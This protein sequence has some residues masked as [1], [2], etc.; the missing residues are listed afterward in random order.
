M[1]LWKLIL[2]EPIIFWSDIFVIF[3]ILILLYYRLPARINTQKYLF[4]YLLTGFLKNVLSYTVYLSFDKPY[5]NT[6]YIA[7]CC[8]V[9]QF[10]FFA[11]ILNSFFEKPQYTRVIK[12][13]TIIF[14]LEFIVDIYLSNP[15]LFDLPNHRMNKYSYMISSI[16]MIIG[17]LYYFYTILKEVNIPNL[18]TFPNFWI[19]CAFLI[20]N[21]GS[22]YV[23]LFNYEQNVWENY[24]DL[25]F[26][27]YLPY[28]FDTLQNILL[29][30]AIWYC[31]RDTI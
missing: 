14:V 31:K 30:V 23:N 12:I 25:G 6:L 4:G 8:L 28:I 13:I 11:F 19:S 9:I 7:N 17:I 3:P 10:V 15:K 29:L 5:N 21:A 24:L 27:P 26:L 2:T 16:L 20:N 1:K 18:L 22:A